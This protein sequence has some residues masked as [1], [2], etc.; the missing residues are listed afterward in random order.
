MDEQRDE[1]CHK[2][3]MLMLCVC[4]A[5]ASALLPSI[6]SSRRG[7]RLWRGF[8]GSYGAPIFVCAGGSYSCILSRGWEHEW[9]LCPCP[10][11]RRPRFGRAAAL[12][13]LR[14]VH[15][16]CVLIRSAVLPFWASCG[17][18]FW[19]RNSAKLKYM[20][21]INQQWCIVRLRYMVAG[22]R[23]FLLWASPF[24]P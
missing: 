24:C 9:E 11:N 18:A 2:L 21:G 8:L 20:E 17:I 16:W 5:T 19:M 3:N 14:C 7:F 4:A 15:D 23:A 22:C 10:E 13:G 1:P 12:Q 6:A